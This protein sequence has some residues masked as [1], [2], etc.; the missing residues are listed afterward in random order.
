MSSMRP[1]VACGSAAICARV[2]KKGHSRTSSADIAGETTRIAT[3]Y[4]A[5]RRRPTK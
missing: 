5:T 3:S 2:L 4:P 1:L